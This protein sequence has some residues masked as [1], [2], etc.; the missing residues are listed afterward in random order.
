[1]GNEILSQRHESELQGPYYQDSFCHLED[2]ALFTETKTSFLNIFT[3]KKEFTSKFLSG[4]SLN[5][6]VNGCQRAIKST[7]YRAKVSIMVTVGY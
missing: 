4:T 2:E 1:M 3:L 5:L 7:L 6:G